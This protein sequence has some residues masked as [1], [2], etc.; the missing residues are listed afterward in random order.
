LHAARL[1]LAHPGTGRELEWEAS[2]PADLQNL[3]TALE[4]DRP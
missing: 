1:G 4:A 2:P 3:L